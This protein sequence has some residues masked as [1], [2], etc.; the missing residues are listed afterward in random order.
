MIARGRKVQGVPPGES[1]TPVPPATHR[2]LLYFGWC[3][4]V[5][6]AVFQ[7]ER[8]AARASGSAF[9]NSYAASAWSF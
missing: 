9:R 4:I 8:A 5:F 1:A 6:I 3:F 7:S 2:Q